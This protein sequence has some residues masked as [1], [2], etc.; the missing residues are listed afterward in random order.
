MARIVYSSCVIENDK[1]FNPFQV[2]PPRLQP[3]ARTV[4][5]NVFNNNRE[6]VTVRVSIFSLNN[7]KRK[8]G[9]FGAGIL[10]GKQLSVDTLPCANFFRYEVHVI[11][12]A[13]N[14]AKAKNVIISMFP[15][16]F[17]GNILA[18]QRL[19]HNEFK[20]ISIQK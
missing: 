18:S 13:T 5:L 14:L 2:R 9:A 6:P 8:R 16:N 17:K 12:E 10:D 4:F 1:G 3:I 20:V 11:V 7:F 19:I 15:K